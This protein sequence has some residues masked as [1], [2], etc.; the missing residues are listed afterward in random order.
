MIQAIDVHAHYGPYLG[1]G[2]MPLNEWLSGDLAL[3]V[4]RA[5]LAGTA[6]TCVSPLR[7]IL[8]RGRADASAANDETR[9]MVEN[10]P[11][12]RYWVVVNPLDER[13]CAQAERALHEPACAGIKI[14]PQEHGYPI[15][16]H[17]GKIF[18]FASRHKAVVE[19]H[20]GDAT[21]MPLDFVYLADAFPDVKVILA[22]LGYGHDGDPTH[23]V[24]AMLTCRHGNL[25]VDTSSGRSILSGLVE[26][27]VKEV[28]PQRILYGTDS[29]IHF[30]PMQR[31]RIEYAEIGEDDK[32]LILR[33]N[34][35][36]VFGEK[37]ILS[38]QS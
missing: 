8:P 12:L 11:Q 36:R 24:R 2:S 28:G 32:R 27:A 3:V 34:A 37:L 19:T 16:E 35:V 33:E 26:W 1:S 5:K 13:T 17:G 22:H 6:L 7:A 4:Q 25:Y 20:S 29:P 14:H 15:A 23:Q 30:A 38:R 21:C 31:A 9:A 18:E 10:C